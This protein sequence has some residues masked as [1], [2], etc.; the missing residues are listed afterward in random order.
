MTFLDLHRLAETPLAT[1][2]FDFVV[3]PGFIRPSMLPIVR[4]TYPQIAQPGSF[5]AD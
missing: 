3:V 4:D 5:P 2:P 1:K